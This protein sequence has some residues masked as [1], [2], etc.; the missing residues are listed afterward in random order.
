M[1]FFSDQKSLQ[2]IFR[3]GRFSPYIHIALTGIAA[4]MLYQVVE[5][6]RL[7]IWAGF[8]A[9]IIISRMIIQIRAISEKFSA[10]SYFYLFSVLAVLQAIT[11]GLTIIYFSGSIAIE[12]GMFLILIAGGA[13]AAAMPF[14]SQVLPLYISYS[15]CL[16]GP[17]IIYQFLEGGQF[18]HMI[19]LSCAVY[20]AAMNAAAIAFNR[21]FR[22]LRKT[23]SF[24]ENQ[25][26]FVKSI[27]NS[28][29][30]ISIITCDVTGPE[31]KI[32][33]F[34][35]GS[36][37]I[38]DS[39]KD[40][41]IG[42]PLRSIFGR[43]AFETCKDMLE[44]VRN[45]SNNRRDI[46]LV[47]NTGIIQNLTVSMYPLYSE[48]GRIY[49]ALIMSMDISQSKH[50]EKAL[51]NS[52]EKFR[53]IIEA[54]P[55]GMQMY[56]L[57]PK[58][59]LVFIGA[60]AAADE[61]TGIDNQK[62]IGLTIE[63]A[64]PKLID[65]GIPEAFRKVAAEGGSLHL[66]QFDYG[67]QQLKKVYEIHAFQTSPG[68]MVS[69]FLNIMDRVT[70]ENALRRSE[71][72]FRDIALS[73]SDWIWET[74]AAGN[75]TF[76]SEGV[77]RVIGYEPGELLGK[78]I[79]SLVNYADA[80]T[81]R[82]S[83]N[84]ISS[85]KK[86][87]NDW[88]SWNVHREGALIC[89]QTNGVPITDNQGKLLGYRGISKDIT[90]QKR[91]EEQLRQSEERYRT[92]IESMEEG[93]LIVSTEDV[94]IFS[95]KS[96]CEI[97]GLSQDKLTGSGLRE[98]AINR[99]LSDI[100]NGALKEPVR[101]RGKCELTLERL[102][103]QTRHVLISATMLK[104]TDGNILGSFGI[105]TDITDL[106]K[107]EREK[108]ELR[109]QL[110]NAQRMESLGILAGG[111]AHDLNNILGP[112]VAYPDLIR[113]KM[114]DD[115]PIVND[116]MKIK[117]SAER[118]AE[119]VQDLLT[120]ARR[121]RYEFAPV[122]IGSLIESYL[123]SAEFTVI[124]SKRP[125][126]LVIPRLNPEVPPANGSEPHL[127]KVIMNLIIN[128][129]DAMP[130]GGELTIRLDHGHVDKLIGGFANIETG[131][132]IILTV[133]DTGSGIE[134]NDIKHIFE[135][136]Y[137]KKK[138]GKSGSGLGLSITYGIVKDHNGYIDVKSE[139]GRGSD[140][141]IYFPIVDVESPARKSSVVDIRGNERILIV[142]DVEEQR[143][144]A[145]TILSSLGY[146]T[147]TAAGGREAIE[148]LRKNPADLVI[149][150]MIMDEGFDGLD[151][152]REILRTNP[153]Q[154]A[155]IVSGFS[156]TDRVREAEKLGVAKYVR[157]PYNMQILGKAIREILSSTEKIRI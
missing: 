83:F 20:L 4:A 22:N 111:V 60:N 116:I 121:G 23:R 153:S 147:I 63:Q 88:I 14:L 123:R 109:E 29:V 92:L 33:S 140:F 102:D 19:A 49:A 52:E 84:M 73:S 80:E 113:M 128:A 16:I 66:N 56:Q 55:M 1:R 79:F 115:S 137:S 58:G 155:V 3:I 43:Q 75:F 95:N 103:G 12:Y 68:K 45:G 48:N 141:V 71:K 50:T 62:L 25:I 67:D 104:N 86:N 40:D 81:L 134:K 139:I 120:L 96:A 15:V 47:R 99:D 78:Y 6:M 27:Y 57:D 35:S 108:I 72:R 46:D 110:T 106:K 114:S 39:R 77:K 30:D 149:L 7:A 89:I 94:V 76:V 127:L 135:P 8:M 54:S 117:K 131:D 65:A 13:G 82:D 32:L 59:R 26:S 97:F 157:K 107:A 93:L 24:L 124:K 42:K 91:Y 70:T 100:Y 51:I 85:R 90:E 112:L 136:F 142:D 61:I 34:S 64:F 31:Y 125:D 101:N 148:F 98:I 154:K 74:D 38:F 118:A 17:I 5:P 28:A 129:L 53:N 146:N 152:Y 130:D 151:T 119:V 150:D 10:T 69:M 133:S 143:D 144:L 138:M 37:S 11:W 122:D 105:L 9:L 126:I 36:E 145:A 132:Y 41:V 2:E 44:K 18:S 87:I 156:E 21:N